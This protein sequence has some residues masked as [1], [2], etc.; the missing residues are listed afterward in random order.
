MRDH[1]S[2]P[3]TRSSAGAG[4]RPLL[5]AVYRHVY[6]D[7]ERMERI[8]TASDWTDLRP[9]CLTDDP[10]ADR[11]RTAM[12]ANVPGWSLARSDLARTRVWMPVFA[13]GCVRQH[14]GRL[15]SRR[16]RVV[17]GASTGATSTGAA[18]SPTEGAHSGLRHALG[19]AE[20]EH[21]E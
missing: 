9:P 3:L 13:G 5:R 6:R 8:L 16:S 1:G 4:G 21:V 20:R 12:D 10:P 15:T 11:Y 18:S 19:H 2:A 14:P 17:A 7:L